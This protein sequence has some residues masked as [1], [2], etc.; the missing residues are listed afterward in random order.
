MIYVPVVAFC[1]IVIAWL[2]TRKRRAQRTTE[3]ILS[4]IHK[5]EMD[6]I[7]E[8][9]PHDNIIDIFKT[10]ERFYRCSGGFKGLLWKRENAVCFVQ[11]GESYVRD[12]N[13]DKQDVEY[14]SERAFAIGFF[15]LASMLEEVIRLFWTNMPHFCA[16]WAS[17]L[18]WE[19]ATQIRMLNLEYGTGQLSI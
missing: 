18:Y 15:I 4:R 1:C 19:A 6:G 14:F 11:L 8:F 16:R 2:I 7:K 9:M 17:Y 10:D 3:D 13:M 12:A 5:G